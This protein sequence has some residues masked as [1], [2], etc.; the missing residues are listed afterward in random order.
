MATHSAGVHGP[1]EVA[2]DQTEAIFSLSLPSRFGRPFP[3]TS[4]ANCGS[5]GLGSPEDL[6]VERDKRQNS[7]DADPSLDFD[8]FM[9]K[10]DLAS[11]ISDQIRT[12]RRLETE[13]NR[14]R[15]AKK[16]TREE[17]AYLHAGLGHMIDTFREFVDPGLPRKQ[18]RF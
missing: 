17:L 9:R 7:D 13:V 16:R 12:L 4:L 2:A 6:A 3:W 5:V 18:G 10:E 14:K 8:A 15:L 11:E 1:A